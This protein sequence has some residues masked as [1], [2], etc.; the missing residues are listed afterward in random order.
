[1]ISSLAAAAIGLGACQQAGAPVALAEPPPE[2]AS[3]GFEYGLHYLDFGDRAR[4]AYGVANSDA[5][6]LMLECDKGSGTL[7]VSDTAPSGQARLLF[8]SGGQESEV[9]GT[10]EPGVTAP[11]I[12]ASTQ[13]GHAAFDAF[14]RTG[15]LKVGHGDE[16]YEIRAAADERPQ[17]E[18]FFATC[19]SVS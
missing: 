17:V 7:E 4:L 5:V 9:A 10:I 3:S 14:R 18:R 1:M 15:T 13:A 2:T 8:A 12:M 19:A 11:I 6:R 16:G